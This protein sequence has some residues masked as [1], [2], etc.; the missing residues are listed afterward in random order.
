MLNFA[1]A[2]CDFL[3]KGKYMNQQAWKT[4]IVHVLVEFGDFQFAFHVKF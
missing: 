2:G 1:Q 3:I 4:L